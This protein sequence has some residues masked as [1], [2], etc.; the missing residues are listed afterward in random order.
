MPLLELRLIN[1]IFGSY[2][3]SFTKNASFLCTVD[4]NDVASIDNIY[5][6]LMLCYDYDAQTDAQLVGPQSSSAPFLNV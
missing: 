3:C 5:F 1:N 6:V 4:N 2:E